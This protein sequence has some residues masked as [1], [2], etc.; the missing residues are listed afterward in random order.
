MYYVITT[1]I[2]GLND[3]VIPISDPGTAYEEFARQIGLVFMQ[4]AADTGSY[5]GLDLTIRQENGQPLAEFVEDDSDPEAFTYAT[6]DVEEINL[7]TPVAS[8]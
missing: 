1:Q 2:E 7:R 6:I 5:S 4:W 3:T 8:R